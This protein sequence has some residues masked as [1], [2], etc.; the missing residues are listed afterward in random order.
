M[1]GDVG[2]FFDK[3]VWESTIKIRV[4][5]KR[6]NSCVILNLIVGITLIQITYGN[7]F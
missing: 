1:L 3:G 2:L 5:M 4:R 6:V 7:V